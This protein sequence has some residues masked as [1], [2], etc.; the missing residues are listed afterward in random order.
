MNPEQLGSTIQIL[1]SDQQLVPHRHEIRILI[2]DGAFTRPP[3][4]S[5]EPL[6]CKDPIRHRWA[7]IRSDSSVAQRWLEI[8]GRELASQWSLVRARE[9]FVLSS[10]PE[11]YQLF[12]HIKNS[13]HTPY[14][15]GYPSN[16]NLKLKFR[17]A[18]E[19]LPH[20]IW[21]ISSAGDP[22]QVKCHC[23][24]CRAYHR[25]EGSQVSTVKFLRQPLRGPKDERSN[26]SDPRH[27]PDSDLPSEYPSNFRPREL[28]WCKLNKTH[29]SSV[30]L[31]VNYWPG[32]CQKIQVSWEA[33]EV[34]DLC[35]LEDSLDPKLSPRGSD[36]SQ[37]D[38][39]STW[40]SKKEL[41]RRFY[42]SIRLLG[43]SD[44]L[45]RA[46][47]EIMPWLYRP[48]EESTWRTVRTETLSIPEYLL[49]PTKPM[50]TLSSLT[51]PLMARL[52]FQFGVQIGAQIEETWAPAE[53]WDEPWVDR[54]L[55]THQQ[56]RWSTG[57]GP[58][59]LNPSHYQSV[60]LGAEKI[61][62]R[63]LVRLRL[64]ENQIE[65]APT[66][67]VES[68]K[69]VLFLYIL[70]FWKND[71]HGSIIVG[72]RLFELV[73]LLEPSVKTNQLKNPP[74]SRYEWLQQ[75]ADEVP[76]GVTIHSGP[77]PGPPRGFKFSPLTPDRKVHHLDLDSIAGRYYSPKHHH[78]ELGRLRTQ[79]RIKSGSNRFLNRPNPDHQTTKLRSLLGTTSGQENHMRFSRMK[80]SRDEMFI[81]A[82][83][84]SKRAL[85]FH[86][87]LKPPRRTN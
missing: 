32:I 56:M 4:I 82:F 81:E 50:P 63:D 10:F 52:S 25:L 22:S 60:W 66:D 34:L 47:S 23:K 75:C 31:E 67:S 62:T 58:R 26:R 69:E 54:N 43:V 59:P 21:L 70:F 86:F 5:L 53:H 38:T 6:G 55:T 76:Q 78:D 74:G 29:N 1:R 9:K 61:L 77:L 79:C 45:V 17:T 12:D 24:F 49:D 35:T 72:G 65:T 8:L 64:L 87:R 80:S 2:S 44:T 11:G 68:R 39:S 16:S 41:H 42:W 30:R 15:F 57:L 51:N 7:E 40:K 37:N 27:S 3:Q 33:W 73:N 18:S 14:L 48:L 13:D 84:T 19:F 85:S 71:H 28:V 36:G 20:L 83:K 46:E